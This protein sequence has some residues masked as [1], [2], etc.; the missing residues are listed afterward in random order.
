MI[1]AASTGRERAI[2][3]SAP[4][5]ACSSPYRSSWSRNRSSASTALGASSGTTW[6]SA[7][8]STSATSTSR[9]G[10]RAVGGRGERR[11]AL[12]EIGPR[13][14]L[15]TSTPSARSSALSIRPVV[16]L[17]LL[18]VMTI[19]AFR[20]LGDEPAQY[21]RLDPPGDQA[22]QGGPIALT[23]SPGKRAGGLARYEGDPEAESFTRARRRRGG[24]P[25]SIQVI[26]ASS[27]VASTQPCV[28]KVRGV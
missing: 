16:V 12:D 22:R 11:H 9:R 3:S 1:Q 5:T 13:R 6:P 27:K 20:C 18:P 2:A 4:E 28:A 8:S 14:L 23:E 10:A 26:R 17:P 19:T 15:R 21:G 24:Q 7:P 25:R